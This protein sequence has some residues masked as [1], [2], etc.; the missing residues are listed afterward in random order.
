MPADA[1]YQP[2]EFSELAGWCDD[3][4]E[5]AYQAFMKSYDVLLEAFSGMRGPADGQVRS[6]K[7]FFEERFR[8]HRVVHD[9]GTGL[10]TGYYE[11]VLR[12]SR[13][14][15]E[16]FSVPLLRRP[17]DLETVIDDSLRAAAG[18][19]M[20]HGRR[21]AEGGFTAY[22]TRREIEE[23]ALD[24]LGLEFVYLEDAVEAFLLH[25]QGSGLIELDSGESVRVSYAAKNG[26]PYTS[27]GK[28]LID[29][30]EIDPA[31]MSLQTLAAWLQADR[32]RGRDLMW[33][34]RSYIF[35]E[36]LGEAE[37]FG[38]QGVRDIE[39]TAGRSLAVDASYHQ[40]GLP[41]FVSV[42][43]LAGDGEE[44]SYN[45]LMIAQDVGSAIRG[46]ERGDLFF[47]TGAEAGALAGATNH[48]G[49]MYV[50]LPRAEGWA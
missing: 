41:V 47:G 33:R 13:V 39:L 36:E 9:G 44:G 31:A 2:L 3:D 42:P 6:A 24:G 37:K 1:T 27:I 5:A 48:A 28:L 38:A 22:A 43:G 21:T 19:R 25:V 35:F 15:S 26:H 8:P 4:H 50:L 29:A 14:R 32:Q 40:I 49:H 12:G 46:P 16:R 45:R 23:G 11:P 20:T 17:G 30:G 34:N 7:L 10:F 18:E